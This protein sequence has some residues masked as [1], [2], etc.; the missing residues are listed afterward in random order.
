LNPQAG[1]P[2]DNVED[3]QD[4]YKDMVAM[5]LEGG[6]EGELD[7]KLGYIKYDYRNKNTDISLNGQRKRRPKH[8]YSSFL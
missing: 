1:L 6:L 5:T 8:D 4:L 7:E 3:V 2:C